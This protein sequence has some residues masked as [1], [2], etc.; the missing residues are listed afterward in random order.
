[1]A[2]TARTFKLTSTGLFQLDAPPKSGVST[3]YEVTLTSYTH[4]IARIFLPA[5]ITKAIMLYGVGSGGAQYLDLR[6]EPGSGNVGYVITMASGDEEHGAFPACGRG[7]G[8]AGP[9]TVAGPLSMSL[10]P[11]ADTIIRLE[12]V[13][14]AP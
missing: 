4:S 10:T 5:N 13:G 8:Y 14:S 12:Y 3:T 6:S 2:L 11:D 7:G 9:A 1:M